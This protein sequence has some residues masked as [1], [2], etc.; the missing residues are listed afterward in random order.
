MIR[1]SVLT[2]LDSLFD[3][4]I[5]HATDYDLFLRIAYQTKL[6]YLDEPLAI[7]RIHKNMYTIKF[8]SNRHDEIIYIITQNIG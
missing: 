4:T 1:K 3:I 7:N 6:A 8:Y 2:Q 5:N